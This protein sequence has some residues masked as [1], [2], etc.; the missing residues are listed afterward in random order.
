MEEMEKYWSQ[1]AFIWD[2]VTCNN[3]IVRWE[4]VNELERKNEKCD[5]TGG[6]K[7]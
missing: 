4:I 2:A 3:F 1:Q 5:G 6:G 7:L